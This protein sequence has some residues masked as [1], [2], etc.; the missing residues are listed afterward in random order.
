MEVALIMENVL[1]CRDELAFPIAPTMRVYHVRM[2]DVL[3]RKY[4]P[5]HMAGESVVPIAPN[6]GVF[7]ARKRVLF[8]MAGELGDVL[9]RKYVHVHMVGEWVG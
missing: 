8:H 6:M 2:E 1:C 4:A 7:H 9:F 3:F 5:V